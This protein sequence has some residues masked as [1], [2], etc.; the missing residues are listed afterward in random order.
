MIDALVELRQEQQLAATSLA[1]ALF[2]FV[3]NG[4]RLAWIDARTHLL[5]NRI[6]LPW[7]PAALL[8][9]GGAA[10]FAGD[11]GALLRLVAAGTALFAFYLALHLVK[12]SGMGLGDVKLAGVLGLYLGY[13]GWEHLVLA[14][15]LTFVLGGI[16]ALVLIAA[17]RAT[18]S[19]A[20]PFGPFMVIGTALALLVAG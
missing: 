4:A 8:T 5:P 16:G 6:V 14:T 13:L 2:L 15:L 10:A 17:R 19:S 12:R 9:L 7:Y 3:V 18:R 20:I 11:W 1:L